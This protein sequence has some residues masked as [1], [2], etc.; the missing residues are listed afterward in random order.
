MSTI[1]EKFIRLLKRK[2]GFYHAGYSP[3]LEELEDPKKFNEKDIFMVIRTF[4]KST[5]T[6]TLMEVLISEEM[7]DMLRTNGFEFSHITLTKPIV[8][9]MF[10]DSGTYKL[11]HARQYPRFYLKQ[12]PL[13]T[14]PVDL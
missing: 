6:K 3:S 13:E 5:I 10:E 2:I 1:D 9:S 7:T 12:I 11:K 8:V 4:S 14:E